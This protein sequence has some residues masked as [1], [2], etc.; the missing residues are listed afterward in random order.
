MAPKKNAKDKGGSV[1]NFKRSTKIYRIA[2]KHNS[3]LDGDDDGI[4]CE[5]A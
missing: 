4:A 2:N 5:K 3:T 1:T